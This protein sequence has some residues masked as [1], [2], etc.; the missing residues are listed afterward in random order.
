MAILSAYNLLRALTL[1]H[2]A[3]SYVLLTN[4]TKLLSNNFLTLLSESM[5]FA[6]ISASTFTLSPA[7]TSILGLFLAITALSDL[8]SLGTGDALRHF[9]D[10]QAPVRLGAFMVTCA[11]TYVMKPRTQDGRRRYTALS[12]SEERES[13]ISNG[14]V[15]TWAFVEMTVWF[16]IYIRLREESRDVQ[17]RAMQ[18]MK[19]RAEIDERLRQNR[20]DRLD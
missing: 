15:F 9:W 6:P 7:P 16:M 20:E 10:A 11:Y 12:M 13:G 8:T 4:P 3:L 19:E 14:L 5:G 17:L 2:F 18:L 1:F